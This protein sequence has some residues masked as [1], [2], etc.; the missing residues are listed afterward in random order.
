MTVGPASCNS[1]VLRQMLNAGANDFRI[2][3]SHSNQKSLDDYFDILEE[4][5]ITPCLDTQGAQL[6]LVDFSISQPSLEIGQLVSIVFG[7]DMPTSSSK[8]CLLVNHPEVVDQIDDGDVLKVDFGG[9]AVKIVGREMSNVLN[10]EVIAS[11]QIIKNRA[12]DVSGKELK[13]NCLTVFDEIAIKYA[14]SRGCKKIYA[15]FIS[16]MEDVLMIKDIVPSDVSIISK[17]ESKTSLS[18]LHA[19]LEVSDAILID[20][21]DLSR[22]ITI[23]MVPMAVNNILSVASGYSKPVYIATNILDSMMTSPVP[24][25]AEISDLFNLLERGASG[26][27]LAAEVAIGAH[28]VQSVAL[29]KYIIDIFMLQKDGMLGL[30]NLPLPS[31]KLVGN[32]LYQWL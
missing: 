29:T 15:S 23:P 5:D 10:G 3:L 22:S 6:R 18:N 2:N 12:I 19:I 17:I 28:P 27:V 25:R 32:E 11:G 9:L 20:R 13:M 24:S 16:R 26:I 4:N 8:D 31:K 21:G 1:E 7:K 30:A 14:V